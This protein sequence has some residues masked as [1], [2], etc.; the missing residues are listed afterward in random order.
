MFRRAIVAFK[1]RS[2]H[3]RVQTYNPPLQVLKSPLLK[4]R[5]EFCWL[6]QCK[7]LKSKQPFSSLLD[8]RHFFYQEKSF[9]L[10]LL[11]FLRPRRL[12]HLLPKDDLKSFENTKIRIVSTFIT[13]HFQKFSIPGC[14]NIALFLFV[15]TIRQRLTPSMLIITPTSNSFPFL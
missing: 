6:H 15:S 14:Y 10:G 12:K 2:R 1:L 13:C 3:W 8:K 9:Q 4:L 11:P 7:T 5:V